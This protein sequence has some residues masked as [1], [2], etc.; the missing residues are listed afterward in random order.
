MCSHS[1]C[2]GFLRLYIPWCRVVVK[3]PLLVLTWNKSCMNMSFK[4]KCYQRVE[5]TLYSYET[6]MFVAVSWM[7]CF[8]AVYFHMYI[9]YMSFL[10]L[11]F[12]DFLLLM[13]DNAPF[14]E[15]LQPLEQRWNRKNCVCRIKSSSCFPERLGNMQAIF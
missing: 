5:A 6:L 4:Y 13:Y 10:P 9:R 12:L 3:I 1:E 7:L 8:G 2:S 11:H 15:M 14:L